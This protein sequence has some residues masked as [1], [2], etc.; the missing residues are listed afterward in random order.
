[1]CVI[2]MVVGLREAMVPEVIEVPTSKGYYC[3]NRQL[4]LFISHLNTVAMLRMDFK[5][6]VALMMGEDSTSLWTSQRTVRIISH[7]RTRR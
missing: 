6:S 3:H 5:D 2:W 4:L 1:M 7:T